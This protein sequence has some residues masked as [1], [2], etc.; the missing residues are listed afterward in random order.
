MT[1]KLSEVEGWTYVTSKKLHKKQPSLPQVRPSERRQ[2]SFCQ[3]PKRCE[4]VE[5]EEISTQRSTMRDLIFLEKLF[6]YSVKAPC[7]EDC[8]E[9]P[10]K[11]AS[12]KLDKQQ[13]SL[14]QVHQSERGQNSS[15]QP[16]E[17]CE[18]VGDN[19]ILTQRSSI[20]I[21]MCDLFPEDFFN[22]S[23]KAPCYEDCEEQLS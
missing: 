15:C 22:Y 20:P 18:S 16:S 5:D 6:N 14:P 4:S 23:I 12:K 2:N 21:T 11:I 1:V 13:P 19:E 3:P 7:Y 9:Y 8:K 17:H 10:S